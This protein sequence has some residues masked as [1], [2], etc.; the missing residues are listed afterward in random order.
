MKI[1]SPFSTYKPTDNEISCFMAGGMSNTEWFKRFLLFITKKDLSNIVIIN[2]Y[3]PVEEEDKITFCNQV[4]W[5]INYLK[6]C[7][8]FSVYFDRFTT[9]SCSMFELGLMLQS[10]KPCI[11]S[12]HEDAINKS[13]LY[14]SLDIMGYSH[15]IQIRT[16][17]QHAEEVIKEYTKLKN[18]D[19]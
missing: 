11:V 7:D 16:P 18:G 5:E 10:G 2:P 14:A 6:S 3:N 15:I 13:Y 8:I 17:E 1:I 4:F 9:Q 19:I 12:L